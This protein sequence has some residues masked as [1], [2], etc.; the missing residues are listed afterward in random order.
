MKKI[1]SKIMLAV[2]STLIILLVLTGVIISGYF[3]KTYTAKETE[4]LNSKEGQVSSD[5][6]LFF[7]HYIPIVNTMATDQNVL[8]LMQSLK[9]G[10]KATSSAYFKD[11]Y[12]MLYKSQKQEADT[13]LTTYVADIDANLLF[14]SDMWISGDDYD[15]TTR[16]WYQA[17]TEKKLIITEPYEDADT[18]NLVVTIATPVFD[19][20]GSTVL[21]ITA[22]DISLDTL[23]N[24][25][26]SYQLGNTGYVMLITPKGQ[27]LSHR[28]E[29][30]ILK[31]VNEIGLDSGMLNAFQSGKSDIIEFDNNGITSMGSCITIPNV[32]WKLIVSIPKAEFLQSVSG[33]KKII[34]GI[35]AVL[36][37][38]VLVAVFIVSNLVAKPIKYL[39]SAARRM[40][41]GELDIQIDVHTKDEVGQLATSLEKLA[42]RLKEYMRY[43]TETAEALQSMAAGNLSVALKQSYEGEFAK[44]KEAFTQAT[45]IINDTVTRITSSSNQVSAGAE[46]VS[47]VAQSLSQGA[48]EQ[49]SSI[50]ELA[51][52]INEISKQVQN[53]ADNAKQA[54]EKA[55]RMGDEMSE[56][57]QK[58]QE[59][60]DAMDQINHSSQ[61]IGK[62]M[63]TIED[64]AFQTNIL[65]LNAAVEAARAGEAGKGFAVVADEVRNLASKSSEASKDTAILIENSIHA[66]ENGTRIADEAAQ[67]MKSAVEGVREVTNTILKISEASDMQAQSILQV[68]SGVE[69]ISQVVQNTS[70]TA[71]ES[72]AA[73]EQMM[74]QAQYL[75]EAVGYFK[76]KEKTTH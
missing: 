31:N 55:G 60:I 18:K 7:R 76:L 52:T 11:V 22:V 6:E 59:M 69:Q 37:L 75:N 3:S 50:E 49:A 73:S 51:A 33:A 54:S 24:T 39:N 8:R 25:V 14:D 32:G 35:Y 36:L 68:T 29:S 34:L 62:I 12:N 57:N 63:K 38:L 2:G 15:V 46:H 1:T 67:T 74:G 23:N 19:A 28:D 65:A 41:D 16:D 40:A 58:M 13:I 17:V 47:D 20:D 71:D 66:V 42:D 26:R 21:G 53:N 70:S 4:L 27:V 43:I 45:D 9:T 61:E 56:S 5:A 44:I 48:T 72:A 64:I 30:M 10:D